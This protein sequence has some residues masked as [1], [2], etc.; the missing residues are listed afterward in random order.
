MSEFDIDD[1]LNVANHVVA[2]AEPAAIP[3]QDP[4]EAAMIQKIRD[5]DGGNFDGNFS[6]D[7]NDQLAQFYGRIG[8]EYRRSDSNPKWFVAAIEFLRQSITLEVNTNKIVSIIKVIEDIAALLSASQNM[9]PEILTNVVSRFQTTVQIMINQATS[10]V[11]NE[12][13]EAFNGVVAVFQTGINNL[14]DR[15]QIPILVIQQQQQLENLI[16]T[17]QTEAERLKEEI[18][19]LKTIT[20]QQQQQQQQ[21][22][23]SLERQLESAQ[24]QLQSAQQQEQLQGQQRQHY[25]DYISRQSSTI[26]AL[27]QQLLTAQQQQHISVEEL[28][29]NLTAAEGT[30]SQRESELS[31]LHRQYQNR[32]EEQD[33]TIGILQNRVRALQDQIGVQPVVQI[34]PNVHYSPG[35]VA[36][37][38]LGGRDAI[39]RLG[40]N[41]NY[42]RR[43]LCDFLM[44]GDWRRGN[45]SWMVTIGLSMLRDFFRPATSAGQDY[46]IGFQRISNVN[47]TIS[48]QIGM[49]GPTGRIVSPLSIAMSLRVEVFTTICDSLNFPNTPP[50]INQNV[51]S[52]SLL[53]LAIESDNFMVVLSLL[54][55][56][57]TVDNQAMNTYDDLI[58]RGEHLSLSSNIVDLLR[59]KNAKYRSELIGRRED[60]KRQAR[61]AKGVS[62]RKEKRQD[63][64]ASRRQGLLCSQ[65]HN[66]TG[67]LG[68]MSDQMSEGAQVL[69]SDLLLRMPIAQQMNYGQR[70]TQ[71]FAVASGNPGGNEPYRGPQQS[72]KPLPPDFED[73]DACAQYLGFNGGIESIKTI[74]ELSVNVSNS[75]TLAEGDNEWRNDIRRAR[76]TVQGE[77]EILGITGGKRRTMKVKKQ[78]RKTN[79]RVYKK[80]KKTRVRRNNKSKRAFKGKKG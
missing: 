7:N 13:L 2:A 77:L 58:N 66:T 35:V 41:S 73:P 52:K 72:Q 46:N 38:A 56:G 70:N 42:F 10:H 54:N 20:A 63:E 5:A 50:N 27:Q 61:F 18:D 30:I 12:I 53:C 15:Q 31:A 60:P 6:D 71:S 22:I 19:K 32:M 34:N 21:H 45:N 29:V 47:W 78:F 74:D 65:N 75:L 37:Q 26:A 1:D 9:T 44:A 67:C 76:D 43:K 57:A 17:A 59:S 3:I 80:G 28:Q 36:A 14:I 40:T 4:E 68:V 23:S 64:M 11:S 55:K 16:K 8:E 79:K 48:T 39:M 24:I 51:I 25:E 62:D 69:Q 49:F 33:D